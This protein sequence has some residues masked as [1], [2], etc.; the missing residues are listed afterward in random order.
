MVVGDEDGSP[1]APSAG[2]GDAAEGTRDTIGL[3]VVLLY[4]E[5]WASTIFMVIFR[6]SRLRPSQKSR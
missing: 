2:L 6:Y 5:N 4:L 3:G 1:A